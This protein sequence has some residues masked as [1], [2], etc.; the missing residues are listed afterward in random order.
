MPQ[1]KYQDRR[2][3]IISII[4]VIGFIFIVRLFFIQVAGDKWKNESLRVSETGKTIQPSRGLIFDRNSVLLAVNKPS[5]ELHVTPRSVTPFDTTELCKLLD[6]DIEEFKLKLEKLHKDPKSKQLIQKNIP[7]KSIPKLNSIIYR[8]KGFELNAKSSRHYPQDAAAH[9]LG[10][11]R[12]VDASTV[13]K[14]PYYKS[15]DVIGVSGLERYYEEAL[16]GK[17]GKHQYLKDVYGNLKEI[18]ST[19]SAQVGKNIIS[20]IDIKLQQY[21]ELLMQ[22]K[23]GGIVALEP[24]TGEILAMISAPTYNPNLLTGEATGKNWSK[25]YLNDSLKPLFNRPLSMQAPP[26]S[27]FKMVQGLVSVELGAITYNTAL[28]C[29]KSLVGCHNHANA[30]SLGE[31]IKYSCNPY[32]FQTLGLI[33]GKMQGETNHERSRKALHEWNKYVESFGLGVDL[34]IDI[35][36]YKNGNIPSEKLYDKM[37]NGMGWNYRTCNSISIGQGEVLIT[38][39]QMAN[40]ASVMANRGYYYYPHF[41]KAIEGDT[42]NS[43][44]LQQNRTKIAQEYFQPMA[45]AMQQVVEGVGGTASRARIDGVIVCGKTGTVQNPHGKDHSVFI[46]FAPKDNP[47]IAIAV[48]VENAGYGGTWAAPIASLMMESYLNDSIK[49]KFK[50]TRIIDANLL[51]TK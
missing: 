39:F 31:A 41:A 48:Y 3:T 1:A 49:N 46:A 10:Y 2:N 21:G 11:I 8:L 13:K 23:M 16:R 33:A 32:F 24:S 9:L 36:Y 22:N 29:N 12:E 40:L 38:P 17:R 15:G 7:D 6:T 45:D 25:L 14:K 37:Y 47:K 26:G 34:H 19:D 27:I 4:L 51:P 5:Y 50:E 18:L 30:R 20:S 28:P 44:Y 35:P 42:I 43:I